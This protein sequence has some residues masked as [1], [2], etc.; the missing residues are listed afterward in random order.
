MCS[1]TRTR[2]CPSVS[3]CELNR[4]REEDNWEDVEEQTWRGGPRV[5]VVMR[6]RAI[7]ARRYGFE[8]PAKLLDELVLLAGGP[9]PQLPFLLL[10]ST[11]LLVRVVEASAARGVYQHGGRHRNAGE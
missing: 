7:Y 9:L 11:T 2:R 1:C 3:E 5:I 6:A 4:E 8:R 10:P